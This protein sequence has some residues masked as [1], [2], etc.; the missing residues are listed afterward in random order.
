MEAAPLV[1]AAE[2]EVVPDA[3][4]VPEGLTVTVLDSSEVGEAELE[5]LEVTRLLLLEG[6][7]DD[8]V[9][10]DE[11]VTEEE[12]AGEVAEVS[13]VAEMSEVA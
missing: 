13:E 2:G 4:I 7:D 11:G 3:V 10:L 6:V 5:L 12:L 1:G 9:G 8:G